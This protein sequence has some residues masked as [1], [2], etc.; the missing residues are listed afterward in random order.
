MW[1]IGPYFEWMVVGEESFWVGVGYFEG[2]GGGRVG[3][4]I[5]LGEK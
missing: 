5:I 3:C 1:V 2:G 4:D